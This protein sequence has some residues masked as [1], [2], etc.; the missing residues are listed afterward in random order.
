MPTP[1]AESSAPYPESPASSVSFAYTISIGS[2]RLKN[3]NAAACIVISRRSTGWLSHVGEALAQPA[4]H[5][6]SG[7][8]FTWGSDVAA[9]SI[10]ATS[11]NEAA[12]SS[13]AVSMPS[14]ATATPASA[15]P[16]APAPVKPT[17]MIALPSRSSPCGVST[18]AAEAR[19]R[20]R[21]PIASVPSTAASAPRARGRSCPRWPRARRRWPPRR[22]TAAAASASCRPARPVRPAPGPRNP[23]AN[24]MP[25]NSAAVASGLPVWS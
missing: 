18:A 17:L 12:S 20:A 25:R 7:C 4:A 9:A 22:D 13:R 10:A 14:V 1:H 8:A 5:Q 23:G 15:G 21:A 24:C 11:T 16:T 6:R 3:T 19:V 2:T